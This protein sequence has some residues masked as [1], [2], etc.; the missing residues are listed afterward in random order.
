MLLAIC[1]STAMQKWHVTSWF[2]P[3]PNQDCINARRW[4]SGTG[5][6]GAWLFW[7]LNKTKN[8]NSK[9]S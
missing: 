9:H 3:E 7:M 2:F 5:G 4:I 8:Q 6:I 1:A